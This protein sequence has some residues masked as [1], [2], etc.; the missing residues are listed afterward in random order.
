MARTIKIDR[1]IPLPT[2]ITTKRSTLYPYPSMKK[3]DSFW[4]ANG[5]SAMNAANQ[6]CRKHD[7]NAEFFKQ[8]EN[9]G[10]VDG[11]RIWRIK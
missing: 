4:T 2:G 3:G 5:Q 11:F 9:Q 1:N 6:Y 10:G 8:S 7:Q